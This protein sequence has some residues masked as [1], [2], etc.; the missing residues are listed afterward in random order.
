MYFR[1]WASSSSDHTKIAQYSL[2]TADINSA[3][4]TPIHDEMSKNR[5]EVW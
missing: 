3:L 1:V 5:D 4:K 2:S